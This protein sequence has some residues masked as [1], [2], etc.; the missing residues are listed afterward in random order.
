MRTLSP[1][2][3]TALAIPM[4]SLKVNDF[5]EVLSLVTYNL[6]KRQHTQDWFVRLLMRATRW[7]YCLLESQKTSVSKHRNVL[8]KVLLALPTRSKAVRF[9]PL[10]VL[11]SAKIIR[12][13]ERLHLRPALMILL[14]IMIKLQCRWTHRSLWSYSS[15]RRMFPYCRNFTSG[16]KTK[17]LIQ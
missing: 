9:C 11:V 1:T 10:N 7:S 15:S 3:W 6:V 2:S 8:T 12:N 14:A 4:T 16:L 13:S 17:T 5:V